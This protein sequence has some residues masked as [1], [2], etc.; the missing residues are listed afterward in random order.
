MLSCK[1][2]HTIDLVNAEEIQNARQAVEHAKQEKL[3]A[4]SKAEE[5]RKSMREHN[6]RKVKLEEQLVSLPNISGLKPLTITG[7]ELQAPGKTGVT[8]RQ[9]SVVST[10]NSDR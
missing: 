3:T 7:I 8:Q 2:T 5:I 9:K 6:A 10:Q 1:V 4:E